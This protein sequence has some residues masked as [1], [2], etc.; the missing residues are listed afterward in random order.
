MS[1][2]GLAAV[3]VCVCVQSYCMF[4]GLEGLIQTHLCNP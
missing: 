1:D 3:Y 4:I 2:N